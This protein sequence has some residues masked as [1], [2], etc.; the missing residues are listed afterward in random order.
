M[1]GWAASKM[2]QLLH[3]LSANVSNTHNSFDRA[4]A[5]RVG[6]D[7]EQNN[8]FILGRNKEAP[9][10]ARMIIAAT[11][12]TAFSSTLVHDSAGGSGK[13]SLPTMRSASPRH[14]RFSLDDADS[15][16]PFLNSNLMAAQQRFS[17]DDSTTTRLASTATMERRRGRSFL[18]VTARVSLW[19][20]Y[21]TAAR[22]DGSRRRQSPPSPMT[23]HFSLFFSVP[24]PSPSALCFLLSSLLFPPLSFP[25][26][27][28]PFLIVDLGI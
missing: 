21:S 4:V 15:T 23:I 26:P 10:A 2:Q 24:S 9:A 22:S 28:F 6:H 27:F 25:C 14:S 8:E 7:S 5:T 17:S 16:S 12:K 1:T 13:E 20:V 19:S 11:G 3:P 18:S